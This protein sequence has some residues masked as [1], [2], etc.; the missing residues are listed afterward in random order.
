MQQ[1][2]SKNSSVK[3][4]DIGLMLGMLLQSRCENVITGMFGDVWKVVNMPAK[5]VL[6]NVDAFYRREGE[7]G[8]ATNGFLVIRDLVARRKQVDKVMMFTDCQLWNSQSHNT[9]MKAEWQQYKKIAPQ[10]QL[11]LFDLAGYGQAPLSINEQDVYLIA[12]WSDKIFDVLAALSNGK[13]AL[14]HI[15]AIMI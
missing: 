12:G 15:K 3:L 6:Q 7:V 1:P 10:A 5:S 14:E 2:V 4:Y 9:T 8:Y 13:K 11:Y